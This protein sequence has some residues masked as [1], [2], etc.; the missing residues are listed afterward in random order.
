[1]NREP[2][3]SF[4]RGIPEAVEQTPAFVA[5]L[6]GN[7]RTIPQTWGNVA[8]AI[9]ERGITEPNPG[10]VCD[11]LGIEPEDLR[12]PSIIAKGDYDVDDLE[13]RLTDKWAR[14]YAFAHKDDSHPY[15]D[16]LQNAKE[17]WAVKDAEERTKALRAQSEILRDQ[18][19]A[20]RVEINSSGSHTFSQLHEATADIRRQRDIVDMQEAAYAFGYVVSLPEFVQTLFSD[21]CLQS[22]SEN[23]LASAL[24]DALQLL[25]NVRLTNAQDLPADQVLLGQCEIESVLQAL[26]RTLKQR[27]YD[28][29][30]TMWD[31]VC[32]LFTAPMRSKLPLFAGNEK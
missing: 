16:F 10:A 12:N 24:N 13:F 26:E 27:P 7:D 25:I 18:H 1:M 15:K 22:F 20:I 4:T 28:Y 6:E 14:D 21:T 2:L 29:G 9:I 3:R 8:S 30:Q 17:Q 19:R 23:E 11:F 5:S 31:A 32:D